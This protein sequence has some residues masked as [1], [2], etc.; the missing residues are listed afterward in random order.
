M[1]I[2]NARTPLI[3]VQKFVPEKK[4]CWTI[5]GANQSGMEEFFQLI[6]GDIKAVVADLL[7]LPENPGIISFKTQQALYES[8]VEKDETDFLGKIDPGTPARAFISDPEKHSSLIRSFGLTSCLDKGYRQL[9][10][11]QSRKL[12]LLSEFT[13][14]KSCLIIQSPFDGLD[15]QSCSELS[16]ALHQLHKQK[17]L[18]ILFVQNKDDIPSFSTHIGVIENHKLS[19]QGLK[20]EVMAQL[21]EKIWNNSRGFNASARDLMA[22][23]NLNSKMIPYP[24]LVFLNN[25]SAG[26]NGK[27]VF[28]NLSLT[29][30]EGDHTLISGPNGSGK[31]TLLQMISGDHSACYRNNLRI[32]G[33]QRG[34]GESI[35]ELKKDMGIVSSELHRNYYVPGSV[36]H[37][38]ISGYFDSIGIYQSYT[39][40]HKAE[41][42]K[43]LKRINLKEKADTS[44]RDLPFSAQRMVLIARALIKVP[45]LLI[46]DEPTQGLDE[47]NR[48]AILD[49]LEE[50]AKENICTI[51]YVSHRTDEF[52]DFFVQHIQL[53]L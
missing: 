22:Q 48:K 31:S 25:G 6:S 30:Q 44:F 12:L 41:A 10:S 32:F 34:S 19:F 52:R 24:E 42:L 45:K 43:W 47:I 15:H 13:K 7:D 14:N 46:L 4:D 11:G 39:P 5:L 18:L 53:G 51:L 1:K 40:D 35:W 8:E 20:D 16:N 36:L 23:K 3:F 38:V 21:P 37:C 29:I 17:I 2:I 26:Y 33:V 9:S 50:I 27:N 49:F 28:E